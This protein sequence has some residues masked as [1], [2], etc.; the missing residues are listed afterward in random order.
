MSRGKKLFLMVIALVVMVGVYYFFSNKPV[1]KHNEEIE[2][3]H[4]Q[5]ELVESIV[6]NEFKN[7]EIERLLLKKKDE[8]IL[9][10]NG[11]TP[12][13]EGLPDVQLN[14]VKLYHIF[15]NFANLTADQ[16]VVKNTEDLAQYGLDNPHVS[17]IAHIKER[18]SIIL[19]IG[20]KTVDGSNYYVRL[21]DDKTIYLIQSSVGNYFMADIADLRDATLPNIDRRFIRHLYIEAKGNKP[22]EI[23]Y[24]TGID[25][26]KVANGIGLYTLIQPY[27]TPKEINYLKYDEIIKTLPRFIAEKFVDDQPVDL[28]TYG[29]DNPILRLKLKSSNE[30]MAITKEVD[31]LFGDTFDG[32]YVYFKYADRDTIYGMRN[33][34]MDPLLKVTPFDIVDKSIY[35]VNIK[36]IKEL[37]VSINDSS[38]VF[39]IKHSETKDEEKAEQSFMYKEKEL[40]KESFRALYRSIIGIS[41]DAQINQIHDAVSHEELKITYTLRDNTKKTITYMGYNDLFYFYQ[42]EDNVY[43]L[44]S[45]KQVDAIKDKIEDIIK[46]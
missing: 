3:Q 18:K 46:E 2:Q 15:N 21:D 6:L 23:A 29:L 16:L 37:E 33:H 31:I 25:T 9:L 14:G 28:S 13:I 40:D 45:S 43:F 24:K 42:M 22:I 34:F 35:I 38:Y 32:D 36:D 20:N 11:E 1:N 7:N 8:N 19:H 17:V 41:A 5:K 39:A 30:E 26:K 27:E 4:I 44:S 10:I 12:T